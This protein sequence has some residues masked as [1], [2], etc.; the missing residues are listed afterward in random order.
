MKPSLDEQIAWVRSMRDDHVAKVRARGDDLGEGTAMIEALLESVETLARSST[1][2]SKPRGAY[3]P[4][5]EEQIEAWREHWKN[6]PRFTDDAINL[7]EI[8]ELDR[9]CNMAIN[10]LLYAQEIDRLRAAPLSATRDSIIE[11]CAMAV[12]SLTDTKVTVYGWQK[13]ACRE[14]RALKSATPDGGGA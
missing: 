4:L 13:A 5:N 10:M 3:E 2:T 7:V 12:A 11:E 9:L 1:A 6:A 8:D 14:I